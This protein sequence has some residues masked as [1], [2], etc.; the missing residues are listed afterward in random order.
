MLKEMIV[1]QTAG[2]FESGAIGD[3]LSK[4][5]QMGFF[6]YILPFML[7]FALVF[8]ILTKVNVFRDNKMV[9]GIIALAVGLMSLQF[10]FVPDFFAQLFPRVGVGLAVILAIFVVAGLFIDPESK[11]INYFLLG[12]GVLVIGLVL[13]QSTGALGWASGSWWEENWQMVVGAI[14]IFII[15][16]LIIGSSS[17]P[18][19]GPGDQYNPYYKR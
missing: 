18:K 8:G 11:G 16:A 2:V 4:W 5:E 6:S 10:N 14:F 9:N 1:L 7:I 13:I 12:I 17:Q 3:L 15:V 19:H